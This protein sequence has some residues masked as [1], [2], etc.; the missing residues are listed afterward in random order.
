MDSRI[1]ERE[2]KIAILASLARSQQALARILESVADV[3]DCSSEGARLL[4]DNVSSLTAMQE[5]IAEAATC[6]YWRRRVRYKGKPSHPWLQPK[7]TIY[8]NQRVGGDAAAEQ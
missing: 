1:T 4:R 8:S 3:V 2:A 5:T 6:L 7:L